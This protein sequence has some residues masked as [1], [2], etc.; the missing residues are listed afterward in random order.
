MNAIQL[1]HL[2]KYYGKSRGILNLNLDVKEGEFFGFIGP[3]GA[4]KSTTIRTLLGLITPSS[5]QAKIFDETIRQRNP[6]IRSHIGYLP[7]EAV[8]YR[9]MNVKDLLKLSADL[10]YKDC[11]AEREILCRRL[12]LDVNR[13]VDELSFGN[14][15]KVAIVSALQHQP[16]LLILDEP[17]SG[18]DPLMQREFFHIIRER[19]EQGATVFLSS[20][21]LSEIQRNCTR[22]AIIREGRIIACDRVEALSKTNAKRISVQ[23]QVSLDSLEEIRDLKENDGVFSFLYGGDIHRLLETLSAGTITD[24]S[25]SDPDL[26]EIFLHYYE[27]GGEQ[28]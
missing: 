20:H 12:Q 16:K 8:F 15:K 27:N 26:D 28:A 22:A 19:N 6:Q 1:S 21:V 2:T 24:L 10:H 18:L 23:G 14:R 3:N 13:K 4:G 25:I 5:G 7:S 9:G 17:T 11:S